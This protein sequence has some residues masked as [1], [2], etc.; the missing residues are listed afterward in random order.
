MKLAAVALI[1]L[2]PAVAFAQQSEQK[3]GHIGDG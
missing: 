2:L 3:E 1:A